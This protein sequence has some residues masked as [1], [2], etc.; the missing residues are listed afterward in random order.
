MSRTTIQQC[1]VKQHT[2][3]D[4]FENE[5]WFYTNPKYEQFHP[6][7]IM[8][9]LETMTLVIEYMIPLLGTIGYHAENIGEELRDL[10]QSLHDA[11]ANHRDAHPVNV[12]VDQNDKLKLI[13]WEVATEDIGKVSVDLY[14]AVAA[15][16]EPLEG[17]DENGIWWGDGRDLSSGD[18]WGDLAEQESREVE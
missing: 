16:V 11:G 14:G 17:Y 18:I 2:Q 9:D 15:G 4:R 1:I 8:H 3:R 13:D 5:L 7:L 6:K 12:V 10:L